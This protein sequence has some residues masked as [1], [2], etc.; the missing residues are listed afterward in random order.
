[1]PQVRHLP[2]EVAEAA[3]HTANIP[4]RISRA[5]DQV[6]PEGVL[7]SVAPPPAARRRHS[8]WRRGAADR[9]VRSIGGA[10]RAVDLSHNAG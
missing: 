9:V 7:I 5:Q 1:M 3:I 6:V 10:R 2:L 4:Y 8:S